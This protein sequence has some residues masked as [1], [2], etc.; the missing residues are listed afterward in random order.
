[1]KKMITVIDL[2]LSSLIA[3]LEKKGVVTHEE[4]QKEILRQAEGEDENEVS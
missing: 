4:I 2:V 3:V 1:M